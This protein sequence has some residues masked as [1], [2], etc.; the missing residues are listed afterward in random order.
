METNFENVTS[1]GGLEPPTFRLTA[2]RANR[3]RH[4]DSVVHKFLMSSIN[5]F[6][7]PDANLTA[8]DAHLIQRWFQ[9]VSIFVPASKIDLAIH[10]MCVSLALHER[11]ITPFEIVLKMKRTWM[12]IMEISSFQNVIA[13]NQLTGCSPID[14]IISK[15][16]ILSINHFNGLHVTCDRV[17]RTMDVTVV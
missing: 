7:G 5:Y 16:L 11:N 13:L 4:R 10:Y 12:T 8:F 14:T 15:Y 1:L 2:E 6:N 9:I 17:R 3:L